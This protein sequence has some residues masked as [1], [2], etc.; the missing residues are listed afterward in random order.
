[1]GKTVFGEGHRKDSVRQAKQKEGVVIHGKERRKKTGRFA[2][3]KSSLKEI[4]NQGRRGT[5]KAE[6]KSKMIHL[7]RGERAELRMKK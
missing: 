2:Y 6:K 3:I 1:L 4:E 5:S 7:N